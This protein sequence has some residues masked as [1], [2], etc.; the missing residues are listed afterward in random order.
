VSAVRRL[1]PVV[2]AETV[3]EQLPATYLECRDMGHQWVHRTAHWD[4][5]LACYVETVE[6][7][8]CTAERDRHMGRDGYLSSATRNSYR[9]PE[10]YLISTEEANLINKEGRAAVRRARISSWR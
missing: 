10:G 1:R 4:G 3:A 6:C 8:R 2:A 5:A 9:Y 7:L